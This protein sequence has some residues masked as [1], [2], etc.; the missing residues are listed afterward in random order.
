LGTEIGRSGAA[1]LAQ[2]GSDDF[3]QFLADF[4]G[5]G[6]PVA[7]PFDDVKPDV[8]LQD[9][10]EQAID[11]AATGGDPLQNIAAFHLADERPLNRL[12]LAS[13]ATDAMNQFLFLANGMCHGLL[14]YLT[15]LTGANAIMAAVKASGRDAI[16]RPYT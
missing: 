1:H 14:R 3:D 11:R 2:I 9:L 7:V 4:D 5:I 15:M 8:I 13:Q 16:K 10:A 12:D 6:P